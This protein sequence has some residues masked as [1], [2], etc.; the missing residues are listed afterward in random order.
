MEVLLDQGD[1]LQV[2]ALTSLDEV[3]QMI[4]LLEQV[5]FEEGWVPGCGLRAWIQSSVYFAVLIDGQL[6]GGMQLVRPTVT[7]RLP[8]HDVWPELMPV[9]HPDTAHTAVFAA[10]REFRSR[11]GL[12]WLPCIEVWRYCRREHI[13]DIWLEATPATLRVYNRLGWC[14]EVIGPLR[15]HWGEDC[16]PCR[17]DLDEVAAT[18]AERAGHSDL[19]RRLLV[20]GGRRREIGA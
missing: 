16:F 2:V 9:R 5:A 15:T 1:G 17:M 11:P 13:R 7:G 14:L 10:R 20:Q 3:E 19:Y 12:L 8:C 6:A 18:I 4:C